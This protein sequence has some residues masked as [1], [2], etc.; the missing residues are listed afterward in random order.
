[1]DEGNSTSPEPDGNQLRASEKEKK[2]NATVTVRGKKY[3]VESS[4]AGAFE[5]QGNV[6]DM[7]NLRRLVQTDYYQRSVLILVS[8]ENGKYFV[9]KGKENVSKGYKD[10]VWFQ[11]LA[12]VENPKRISAGWKTLLAK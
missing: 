7:D 6:H 9:I 12:I 10:S 2:M 3:T 8:D 11:D 4:R 1:M 5:W